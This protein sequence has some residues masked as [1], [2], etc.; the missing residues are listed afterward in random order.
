MSDRIDTEVLQRLHT[1]DKKLDIVIQ[2]MAD[3]EVLDNTRFSAV[4]HTI[5]LFAA[6]AGISVS[7]IAIL[8]AAF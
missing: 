1:I 8:I 2:R 4:N 6:A 3:H 7:I 5:G